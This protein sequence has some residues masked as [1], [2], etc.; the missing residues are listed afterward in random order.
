MQGW[1]WPFMPVATTLK[2]TPANAELVPTES[3]AF[4]CRLTSVRRPI[5]AEGRTTNTLPLPL[6][7]FIALLRLPTHPPVH[8]PALH[9]VPPVIVPLE[10]NT[11]CVVPVF[12]YVKLPLLCAI[13]MPH[14]RRAVTPIKAMSFIYL[15][16]SMVNVNLP[17]HHLFGIVL[18]IPKAARPTGA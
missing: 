3:V 10:F 5:T 7:V 4:F 8:T 13:A 11:Q 6:F 14:D 12:P 18:D 15:L 9:V 2:S 17:G 1:C 16:P